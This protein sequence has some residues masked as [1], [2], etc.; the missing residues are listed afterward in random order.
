MSDKA[1]ICLNEDTGYKILLKSDLYSVGNPGIKL[2]RT[3][4]KIFLSSLSFAPD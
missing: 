1:R 4:G 3:I 2:S